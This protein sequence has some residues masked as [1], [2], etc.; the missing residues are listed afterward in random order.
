ME[1]KQVQTSQKQT[2]E[3]VEAGWRATRAGEFTRPV[4]LKVEGNRLRVANPKE[5]LRSRS[6]RYGIWVY[7]RRGLDA[8]LYLEILH[9]RPSVSMEICDLPRNICERIFEVARNAWVNGAYP[10]QVEKLLESLELGG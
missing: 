1:T 3:V 2:D 8:L 7:N 4:A 5:I 6:G 9:G 10:V